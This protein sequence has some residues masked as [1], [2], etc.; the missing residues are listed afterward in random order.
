MNDTLY[1]KDYDIMFFFACGRGTGPISRQVANAVTPAIT[2]VAKSAWIFIFSN[3]PEYYRVWAEVAAEHATGSLWLRCF[4]ILPSLLGSFAQ[5]VA[6]RMTLRNCHMTRA[7]E[8]TDLM[9]RT[10]DIV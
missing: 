2:A 8:M 1:E 7:P 5:S 3:P 10:S 9:E 6:C 4:T